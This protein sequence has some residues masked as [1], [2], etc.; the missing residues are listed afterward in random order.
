MKTKSS[1]IQ[2]L[3][4]EYITM[5]KGSDVLFLHGGSVSFRSNLEFI[6]ELSH[7]YKVWAF[8]FPGAGKSS[9]LPQQWAFDNYREIVKNFITTFDINPILCGHSLGGAIALD[10]SVH[11]PRLC[12]Q[13]ILLAPAGV[14]K[15]KSSATVATVAW[16]DFLMLLTGTM[17]QRK[18]IFFNVIYHTSDFSKIGR[19]FSQ[20][21][22]EDL[23]V[24]VK[25]NVLLL[26]GR[27]DSILPVSC[28]HVF[29]KKL[30]HVQTF[31]VDGTHNFLNSH[32]KEVVS[33]LVKKL[34]SE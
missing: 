14:Q 9:R 20:L 32:C 18:D 10:V 12:K 6:K 21:S 1:T 28:I 15:K 2:N 17:E 16:D 30:P 33:I 22:L 29:K 25:K 11:Y 5:G 26:W 23:L 19:M 13:L 31:L 7:H 34:E 24:K 27:N 4:V 8:S 3:K